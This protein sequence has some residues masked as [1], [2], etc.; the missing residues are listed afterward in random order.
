M[1]GAAARMRP[2]KVDMKITNIIRRIIAYT[3]T[4]CQPSR[5]TD[6][7][8][9]PCPPVAN[10][11]PRQPRRRRPVHELAA[12]AG[13]SPVPNTGGPAR[14]ASSSKRTRG[15]PPAWRPAKIVRRARSSLPVQGPRRAAGDGGGR[16]ARG[17]SPIPGHVARTRMPSPL[18]A[19]R[20]FS[21]AG[22]LG[23]RAWC[24][25]CRD[26]RLSGSGLRFLPGEF[27][28][29]CTPAPEL[30]VLLVVGKVVD[31]HSLSSVR[32][33]CPQLV[34]FSSQQG[35]SSWKEAAGGNHRRARTMP[36]SPE[37]SHGSRPEFL[38]QGYQVRENHSRFAALCPQMEMWLLSRQ[39]A[40]KFGCVRLKQPVRLYE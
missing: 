12:P 17:R 14:T 40:L 3:R 21:D 39:T 23:A 11:D 32:R 24:T 35:L 38:P 33:C 27:A 4:A 20:Q 10:V 19:P 2:S 18:E 8:Q 26:A 31:E 1:K 16:V 28:P 6:E 13:G 15:R 37:K 36:V 30:E 29:L 5:E 9:P 22:A 34:D 7:Y 25:R